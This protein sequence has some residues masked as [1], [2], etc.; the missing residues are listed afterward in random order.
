MQGS[1]ASKETIL[2]LASGMEPGWV[3]IIPRNLVTAQLRTWLYSEQTDTKYFSDKVTCWQRKVRIKFLIFQLFK[4]IRSLMFII[5]IS[6]WIVLIKI[7]IYIEIIYSNLGN[8][9][10]MDR[11]SLKKLWSMSHG[12]RML[13]D[14]SYTSRFCSISNFDPISTQTYEIWGIKIIFLNIN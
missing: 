2:K 4:Y 5:N 8:A 6:F 11:E 13:N 12:F 14:H 9:A 10:L 7:S 3:E 1:M